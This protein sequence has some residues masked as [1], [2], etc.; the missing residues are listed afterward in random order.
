MRILVIVGSSP[1]GSSRPS[2]ALRFVRAAVAVGEQVPAVFFHDDGVY[3]AVPGGLSD[4]GLTSPQAGWRSLAADFG[5]DLLLCP[6]AVGRRLPADAIGTA[7][8]FHEQGLGRLLELLFE[9]DRVV[10]F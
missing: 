1:W 6:A 8:P 3:N 2:A 10:R 7:A 5:V 4:D 9:C